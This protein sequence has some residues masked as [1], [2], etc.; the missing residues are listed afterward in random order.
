M[1]CM[2]QYLSCHCLVNQSFDIAFTLYGKLS[3][4]NLFRYDSRK[5]LE[6][7]T[8]AH[9]VLSPSEREIKNGFRT[10]TAG[11]EQTVGRHQNGMNSIESVRSEYSF[12]IHCMPYLTCIEGYILFV[13]NIASVPW[14]ISVNNFWF[15]HNYLRNCVTYTY[16][17]DIIRK[18]F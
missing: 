14:I 11:F 10:V 16:V 4:L 6:R 1:S 17:L 3:C 9:V 2:T 12:I 7:Q 5:E 15:F 13:Y 8:K 18:V